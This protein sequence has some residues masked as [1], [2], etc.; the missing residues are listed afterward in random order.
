[1]DF[2]NLALQFLVGKSLNTKGT[3]VH[4]GKNAGGEAAFP[5]CVLRV[6]STGS[7]QALVFEKLHLAKNGRTGNLFLTYLYRGGILAPNVQSVYC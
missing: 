4:E 6:T 7:V 1:M 5:P 2:G 3:K